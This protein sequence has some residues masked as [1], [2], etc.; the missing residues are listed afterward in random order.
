ML[1]KVLYSRRRI[2]R[3]IPFLLA[4]PIVFKLSKAVASEDEMEPFK[5]IEKALGGRIGIAAVDT[6]NGQRIGYRA[7]ER[8]PLCSTFKLLLVGAVLARIDSGTETLDRMVTYT[9]SDILDYAPITKTHL[10]EGQMSINELCQAAICYSDN[11]AGNLLLQSV[12]GTQALNRYIRS[13]GDRITRIDRAEPSI[14]EAAPGDIR[15][16]TSP[17]AML[18]DMETLLLKDALSQSSRMLLVN[19]LIGNTTGDARLRA[20]TPSAWKI[21]DKTGSGDHGTTNDIAVLWP[22]NRDPL[23]IAAYTTESNSSAEERNA[24]LA[25]M[26]Q[27]AITL[28]PGA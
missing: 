27:L 22:S 20:G 14:N 19:W 24:A 18:Q 8:F 5:K 23:L 9:Q 1:Y 11:T 10:S 3:A 2:L 17:L 15:D 26:G 21:G 13:L 28:L 25:Q 16:T 12:G 6:A 7:D 4:M